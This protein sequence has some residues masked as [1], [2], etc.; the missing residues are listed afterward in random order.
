MG[1]RANIEIRDHL[2]PD[3]ARAVDELLAAA[4]SVDGTS[5]IDADA[6]TD[7]TQE[8]RADLVALIAWP[9]EHA[10]PVGYAQVA[11]GPSGWILDYVVDPAVRVPGA[12][13]GED[14]AR[15][16]VRYVARAGGGPLLLWIAGP[17]L[18][19]ER[20]AAAAGLAP[21]R[22][23]YQVRRPL[24]VGADLAATARPL[25]TRPFRPGE[26]ESA[27]LEVNNRAFARHPEQ[28]GWDLATI[29]GRE[30]EPW[31]DP[32]GFLLHADGGRLTGFCWTK[33]HRD[34]DPV[35]GEIYVI[36]VDPDAGARGLGRALVLAGLDHLA[37]QGI[38]VGMLY[39]DAANSGAVKLYVDLGFEVDHVKRAYTATIEPATIDPAGAKVGAAS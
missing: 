38:T 28:G 5:A 18:A 24:P 30:A 36:G 11:R 22:T 31:F 34:R 7:L 32:H 6:L 20:V 2:E 35:E 3:A 21:T 8:G 33:V 16:A 27:W 17:R 39:V 25:D 4:E 19:D 15:E 13:V 37:G 26:D 1:Q 14:L 29:A 10:R 12:T 9:A 23:L